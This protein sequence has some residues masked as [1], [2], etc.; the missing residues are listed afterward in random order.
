MKLET[1]NNS[2]YFSFFF[3]F[4]IPF[5]KKVFRIHSLLYNDP[6]T[7]VFG[8]SSRCNDGKYVLL[9]DYDDL[10]VNDII[11]ELKFLQKKHDLSAFYVFKL[12]DRENS[13]HAVCLDKL[14]LFD[15]WNIL[16]ES[17]CDLAFINAIKNLRSRE[18]ILRFGKKGNRDFPI[19]FLKIPSK[20]NKYE[21]SRAH[22]LFLEKFFNLEFNINKGFDCF[23]EIG[24]IKYNTAN[25]T[26]KE[27]L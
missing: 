11:E 6:E 20:N 12:P 18:W 24:I 22:A 26:E 5:F 1:K 21:K 2:K 19:F 15:C 23:D 3:S 13:Y 14:P 10:N 9:M 16:K 7:W 27:A 4:K 25:R 8:Y 17:S